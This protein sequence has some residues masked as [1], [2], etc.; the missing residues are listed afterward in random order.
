MRI[1]GTIILGAFALIFGWYGLE[2]L[3]KGNRS[4]S[5]IE[6][7]PNLFSKNVGTV[8]VLISIGFAIIFVIGLLKVVKKKMNTTTD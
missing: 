6:C 5:G 3:E 2:Y 1:L 8:L 4:C 7:M